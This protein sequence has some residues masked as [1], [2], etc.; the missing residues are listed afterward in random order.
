MLWLLFS[1]IHY[2]II[3]DNKNVAFSDIPIIVN[4]NTLVNLL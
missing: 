2:T 4:C 3:K 1:V